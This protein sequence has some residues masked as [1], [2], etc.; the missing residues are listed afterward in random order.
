MRR[1]HDLHIAHRVRT[2]PE[3]DLHRSHSPA[4]FGGLRQHPVDAPLQ[5]GRQRQPGR[6]QQQHRAKKYSGRP[7][8]HPPTEPV[9]AAWKRLA[10][11]GGT[12]ACGGCTQ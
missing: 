1:L 10:R 3:V 8:Q 11:R 6:N 2:P 12:L 7:P 9:L 4:V 5:I